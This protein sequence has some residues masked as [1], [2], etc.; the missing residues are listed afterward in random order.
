MSLQLYPTT[1]DYRTDVLSRATTPGGYIECQEI[2][3]IPSSQDGSLTQE[4]AVLQ[5]HYLQ[6]EAAQKAGFDL[7]NSGTLTK[8]RLEKVGYVDVVF[9]ELALPI[10]PWPADPT[11]K[12]AGY[13][14][15]CAMLKGLEG[16]SL[17]F[18]T[19]YLGWTAQE[20]EILVAKVR[21]EWRKPSI[22]SYWPL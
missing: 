15:L 12:A 10:G 9:K 16:I 17:R 5:W 4:S 21:A 3:Y 22:H 6:K 8:A 13:H 1:L 18:F 7:I 14:Q 20:V 19:R 2:S 11:L